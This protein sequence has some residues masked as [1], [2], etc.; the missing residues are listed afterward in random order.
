MG[1]F[2]KIYENY[3]DDYGFHKWKEFA[4][5]YD[6]HVQQLRDTVIK[7]GQLFEILEIVSKVVALQELGD[8]ILAH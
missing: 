3:H 2:R 6:Q 1:K 5:H 7:T 8:N 4:P